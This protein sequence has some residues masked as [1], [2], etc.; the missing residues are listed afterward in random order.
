LARR[1]TGEVVSAGVG[2]LTLDQAHRIRCDYL[3]TES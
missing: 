1:D 2:F 3:F